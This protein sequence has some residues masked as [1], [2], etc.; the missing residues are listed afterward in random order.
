MV[1]AGAR[2][3]TLS[4][5][6]PSMPKND[7]D[8]FMS[9]HNRLRILEEKLDGAV[10]QMRASTIRDDL[11][12]PTRRDYADLEKRLTGLEELVRSFPFR[13]PWPDPSNPSPPRPHPTKNK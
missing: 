9:L 6:L 1:A 3:H 13:S 5:F 4:A 10:A 7:D 8:L 12:F 11:R 2:Q